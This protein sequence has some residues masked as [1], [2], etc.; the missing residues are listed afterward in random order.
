MIVLRMKLMLDDADKSDFS[1][2]IMKMLDDCGDD[3]RFK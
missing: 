2:Q 1:L 3:N